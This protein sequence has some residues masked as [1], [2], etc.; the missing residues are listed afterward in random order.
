[1]SEIYI[2]KALSLNDH[3]PESPN[4]ILKALSFI[5]NVEF[6]NFDGDDGSIHLSCDKTTS[7]PVWSI[8]IHFNS[9]HYVYSTSRGTLVE[10]HKPCLE[11]KHSFVLTGVTM[12]QVFNHLSSI[13]QPMI[14]IIKGFRDSFVELYDTVSYLYEFYLEFHKSVSVVMD[15]E[16][17]IIDNS[18]YLGGILVKPGDTVWVKI[19]PNQSE[20][21]FS[22]LRLLV[23]FEKSNIRFVN[24]PSFIL[25]YDD[26]TIPL[27]LG[28]Y[29]NHAIL[30]D[31]SA[32][33]ALPDA[34]LASPVAIKRLNG[35]GGTD[36]SLH[37]D[38]SI[39]NDLLT[40]EYPY[41][42]Q[43]S[44]AVAGANT[45]SRVF[46]FNGEFIGVVDRHANGNNLCNM[47]Q[48]GGFSLGKIDTIFS[49]KTL[50][51]ELTILSQFLSDNKCVIAGIDVLNNTLITEVNISNPSVFKNYINLSKNNFLFN[52]PV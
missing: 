2:H 8:N 28:N 48:G 41:I 37:E 13:N 7:T 15:S 24:P 34:L 44:I 9:K 30:S 21:Y 40:N 20:R 47:T 26:K 49:N 27:V 52:L 42:I 19:D 14:H 36:V 25:S 18:L 4:N 32:V 11:I 46:W 29:H 16:I 22:I 45:D 6:V 38:G 12:E 35:C 33:P 51:A 50:A 1:L 3:P 5:H 39:L 31:P 43:K 10:N 23:P 17:Y